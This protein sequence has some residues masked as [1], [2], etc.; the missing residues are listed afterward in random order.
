MLYSSKLGRFEQWFDCFTILFGV[1]VSVLM[2]EYENLKAMVEIETE[3]DVFR[4]QDN[5]L[6]KFTW[7]KKLTS[8]NSRK[9]KY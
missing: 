8:K 6:S 2:E 1:S 4:M 7:I 5:S 9:G 3:E